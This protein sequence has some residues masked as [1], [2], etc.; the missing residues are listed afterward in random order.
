[1]INRLVN[2]RRDALKAYFDRCDRLIPN[3]PFTGDNLANQADLGKHGCVAAYGF[4]EFSL[5]AILQAFVENKSSPSIA[6]YVES[7]LRRLR[8]LSV[9]N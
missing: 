5:I 8:N 1:M 3:L 9:S 7:R 6:N 4:L 2:G